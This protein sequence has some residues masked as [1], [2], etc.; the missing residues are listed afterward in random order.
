MTNIIN[1]VVRWLVNIALDDESA[2]T[3]DD[4]DATL[5]I[6]VVPVSKEDDATDGNKG[7]AKELSS[8][9]TRLP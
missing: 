2:D 1:E 5:T 6:W 4:D 7:G 9:S 3:M 8:R